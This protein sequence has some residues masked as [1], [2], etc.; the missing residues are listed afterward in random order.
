MGLYRSSA[1]TAT[2]RV[3][4]SMAEK[5]AHWFVGCLEGAL[6]KTVLRHPALSF[7]V[8]PPIGT[9]E[10]G[11]FVLQQ[12]I[13]KQDVLNFHSAASLETQLTETNVVVGEREDAANRLLAD[14]LGKEHEQLFYDADRAPSWR[15]SVIR[16]DA[17]WNEP[18]PSEA[19]IDIAYLAHH[20]LSDGMSGTSFHRTLLEYLKETMANSTEDNAWPISVPQSLK[21]FPP[22]EQFLD[23]SVP[24]KTTNDQIPTANPQS[25][26]QETNIWP[27]TH[28]KMESLTD[29]E[30]CVNNV[31][32]IPSIQLKRLLKLCREHNITLTGLLHG[33]LILSLSRAAA[34]AVAFEGITPI[35]M[36]Q[37]TDTSADEI[38]NHITYAGITF[39]QSLI[40][41][42]RKA[43]SGA[44]EDIE[45]V[46]RIAKLF[47]DEMVNEMEKA[48]E[49]QVL[50][51]I[52]SIT[53]LP[54]YL[55]DQMS[56]KRPSTY[57]LSNLGLTAMPETTNDHKFVNLEK[58]VFTQCGMATGPP[59]GCNCVSLQG[60]PF[61]LTLTWQKDQVS[62]EVMNAVA[63]SL[64]ENIM[65][66]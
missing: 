23:L 29:Y 4:P 40:E 17:N 50:R 3:S 6:A 5:P 38:V 28:P 26:P 56:R 7:G 51:D 45:L 60:G 41:E 30:S 8:Q 58:L 49:G 22:V 34:D 25:E 46:T 31:I 63:E 47:S 54:Q 53:D 18:L 16:Y 36:R 32:E 19:R 52:A 24:V 14:L 59:I 48:G 1:V 12:R 33:F 10:E 21:P 39:K 13:E 55:K 66:Y 11:T 35:S 44:N 61:V 64:K 57:E 65:R 37:F 20:A 62:G 2:Y 42:I 15:L 43:A 9:S 27:G